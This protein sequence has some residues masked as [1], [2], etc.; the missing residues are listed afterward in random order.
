MA[1]A[2]HAQAQ[3]QQHMTTMQQ[4]LLATRLAQQE[5]ERETANNFYQQQQR[6]AA[7]AQAAA[8]QHHHHLMRPLI[9]MPQRL[10]MQM[11]QMD[12]VGCLLNEFKKLYIFKFLAKPCS[13]SPSYGR[14]SGTCSERRWSGRIH[15]GTFGQSSSHCR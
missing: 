5:R 6:A 2:A 4:A 12:L 15:I 11:T 13:S 7:A 14:R 1:A 8:A 10:P 3:T 9:M